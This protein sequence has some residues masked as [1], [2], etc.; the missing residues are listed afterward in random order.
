MT[1]PKSSADLS[2][3]SVQETIAKAFTP[4]AKV[5]RPQ[6]GSVI[7]VTGT[8]ALVMLDDN[9]A[10]Q[11]TG[12]RPQLG[13]ILSIDAGPNVALATVSA[14]SVP[15]PS[16]DDAS[17]SLRVLEAEL[18]GEFSKPTEQA[19][20]RFRRGV[21]A[22]PSLGDDVFV[23]SERE[24]TALFSNSGSSNVRIGVVTQ[25]NRIPATVKV[26]ELFAR[27]CAILG[28]TGAGK[29]CAT[30]LL[31]RSVLKR[32]PQAHIVILD[33][34]NEY[35]KSF[36]EHAA[37]LNAS[38]FS[39]PYWL[40]TFE[41]LLDVVFRDQQVADEEIGILSDLIPAARRLAQS[42]TSVSTKLISVQASAG[43]EISVDTPTPYR[44]SDLITLV[45]KRLAT[46]EIDRKAALQRLRNRLRGVAS[47]ARYAFMFGEDSRNDNMADILATLFRVPAN[48]QPV[49]IVELGALPDDVISIV[50][51]VIAR[52]TF[53]FGLW[54]DGAIPIGLVVEEAHRFAPAGAA[55]AP[56]RKALVRIAKEGRKTGAALWVVSQR[57]VEV[58]PALLSQCNTIFSM[59]LTN[60]ADRD[61]LRQVVPD[62]S[63]TLL[64]CLP[65]LGVGEAI[66]LGEGVAIPTRIA[67][68]QLPGVATPRSR[69]TSFT[70]GWSNE[71]IDDGFIDGVI[72]RWREKRE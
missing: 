33:T 51:S 35:S 41:E 19:P 26:E 28:S 22:Y 63:A 57:P 72:A 60:Q 54:S 23:A 49:S 20:S 48:G 8:H 12:V 3:G 62:A 25:D 15:A 50:V 39:L 46:D 16:L 2:P 44:F 17:S 4:E 29:S 11:Q 6:I 5:A 71:F 59:R 47:D 34:H 69:T 61:A 40:L 14:M 43:D 1:P 64:S 55:R 10:G 38:N 70:D 7:S 67:F 32:H 56:A 66:A 18:L 45:E 58:D 31:L 30:A 52:L 21:S 53:E 42:R 65:T 13:T 27:H 36:G 24:L 68:D 37:I 9:K